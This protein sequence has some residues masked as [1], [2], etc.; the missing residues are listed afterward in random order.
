LNPGQSFAGGFYPPG[1]VLFWTSWFL[2]A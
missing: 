2:P 1:Y